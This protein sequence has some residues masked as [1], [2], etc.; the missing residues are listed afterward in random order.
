MR[1]RAGLAGGV[2]RDGC[3]ALHGEGGLAVQVDAGVCT[4][5]FP[6]ARRHGKVL[7]RGACFPAARHGVAG[8][9]CLVE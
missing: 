1:A 3:A 4:V 7:C 9:A 5:V 2:A 6:R 8:A